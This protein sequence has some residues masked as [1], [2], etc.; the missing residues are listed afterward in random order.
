ME[1]NS[2]SENE[3]LI[4]SIDEKTFRE[5]N[6]GNDSD[7]EFN[8]SYLMQSIN[9]NNNIIN[10]NTKTNKTNKTTN[11]TNKTNNTNTKTNINNNNKLNYKNSN[12][13][14]KNNNKNNKENRN[15]NK[16]KNNNK[17]NQYFNIKSNHK[18]T[19]K[20]LNLRKTKINIP[21]KIREQV[22]INYNG[23]NFQNKCYISWCDNTITVFNYHVGHNIPESKGGSLDIIN[24]RPICSSCNLSMSN[25]FTIT[26]WSNIGIIER[27]S[28]KKHKLI[29]YFLLLLLFISILN[30]FINIDYIF[31]LLGNYEINYFLEKYIYNHSLYF[32][33]YIEFY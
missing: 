24:L 30:N 31:N 26:D 4:F 25:N 16:T 2:D 3:N 20:E 23:Y 7:E 21:K 13:Y 18:N 14:S 1:T 5:Y 22:W 6:L 27:T 10:T 9:N 28:I 19:N 32:E 29:T 11:K 33:N 15:N 17:N 8:S 12:K